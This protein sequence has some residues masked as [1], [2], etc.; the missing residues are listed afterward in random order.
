PF[1]GIVKRGFDVF[2]ASLILVITFPLMVLFAFFIKVTSSGSAIYKQKRLGKNER[3]FTLYK[4]R[5]MR[6]DA[7]KNGP[8]WSKKNDKRITS[9]GK[10]LRRT[11]LDELPQLI[12][13]IKGDVSFVGPR[14]ERPEFVDKLEKEIPFYEIRHITK[15]GI[16]GWAQV[17]YR[18]G[19]SVKD[20][21]EKLKYDLHY[22]RRSNLTLDVLIILKTIRMFFFNN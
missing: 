21:E 20:S 19:S 1:Y 2:F 10:F 9:I 15:P 8:E 13:V 6:K 16:T 7:E 11:H 12:N 18:Y 3:L 14:P 4:F 22:I 5:T 17:M